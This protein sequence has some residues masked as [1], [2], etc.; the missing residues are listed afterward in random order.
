MAV[1]FPLPE[2]AGDGDA[3]D[4]PYL[5]AVTSFVLCAYFALYSACNWPAVWPRLR[6]LRWRWTSLVWIVLAL[7]SLLCAYNT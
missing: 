6:A 3:W 5:I 7:L 2:P 1:W 4:L